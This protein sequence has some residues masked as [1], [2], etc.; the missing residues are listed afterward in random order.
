MITTIFNRK[1]VRSFTA[2]QPSKEEIELLIRAG[3]SAPSADNK[4][5]WEFLVVTD[6]KKIDFLGNKI[7][8]ARMLTKATVAIVVCGNLNRTYSGWRKEFWIQDCSAA[9]QNIL[10]AAE[11]MY[12]AAVWVTVTPSSERIDLVKKTFRLPETIVPLNILALGYP[13]GV[14]ARKNKYDSSKIHWDDW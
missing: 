9:S 13:D 10:L 12:L 5:P 8:Y 6:R 1:S 3:M 7:P 11:S 2:V 4:Q 14:E